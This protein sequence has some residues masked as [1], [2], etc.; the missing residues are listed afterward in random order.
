MRLEPNEIL[1]KETAWLMK[2]ENSAA[3][4]GKT[5]SVALR[6]FSSHTCRNGRG[7]IIASPVDL[8]SSR[9]NNPRRK[10]NPFA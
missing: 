10:A 6:L 4:K 8:A 5:C 3:T 9:I 2:N 1:R 7:S